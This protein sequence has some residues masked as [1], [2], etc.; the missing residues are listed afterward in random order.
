MITDELKSNDGYYKE[1]KEDLIDTYVRKYL[2]IVIEFIDFVVQD[3]YKHK[4]GYQNYILVK[5]LESMSHIFILFMMYTCNIDMACQNTNKAYYYYIEFIEQIHKDEHYFLR[6]NSRDAILFI[7]K[8][9][10]YEMIPSYITSGSISLKNTTILKTLRS[11]IDML[12]EGLLY[13][14]LDVR[15]ETDTLHSVEEK[16]KFIAKYTGEVKGYFE[17]QIHNHNLS[18][19][20]QTY[21]NYRNN[22][23]NLTVLEILQNIKQQLSV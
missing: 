12:N 22:H 19:S 11:R 23:T 6:F 4:E 21:E 7:Y 3:N 10:I 15:K 20:V 14:L 18:T 1:L 5:G 9:T 17:H 13:I 2:Q 16:D 8:K